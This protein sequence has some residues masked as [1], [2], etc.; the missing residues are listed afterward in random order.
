MKIQSSQE[1]YRF[2]LTSLKSF[3]K[4]FSKLMNINEAIMMSYWS[5]KF[6]KIYLNILKVFK[7]IFKVIIDAFCNCKLVKLS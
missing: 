4:S 7:F 2:V 5:F 3:F 1:I 6:L